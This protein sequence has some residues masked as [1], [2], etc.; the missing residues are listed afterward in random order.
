M[1]RSAD[2]IRRTFRRMA[3]ISKR[4]SEGIDGDIAAL[5][6]ELRRLQAE[7]LAIINKDLIGGLSIGEGGTVSKGA[8]NLSKVAKV[9]TIFAK[10]RRLFLRSLVSI[11]GQN[12]LKIAGKVAEYFR[13]GD[14]R[15]DSVER[16]ARTSAAIEARIG[17]ADGR[18]IVGGYLDTLANTDV[19]K[20]EL[21]TFMLR[22]I[23]NG[24]SLADLTAGLASLVVGNAD[25]DGFLVR[26]FRQYAYDTFN[27]VREIK[28]QEFAE[29]LNL[30]WFI[31]Q[32]SLIE[33]SRRFCEKRAGKV[34][35]TEETKT[36]KNDQ[37]LV[38]PKTKNTYNPLIE[39]GRYNCRHW[40]DYISQ[41]TAEY[42][43]ANP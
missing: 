31:Y 40:I 20:Q 41:E 43:K 3:A 26:Y 28:N 23:T 18:L 11:F 25:A 16:V 30:K 37:D 32:G 27:Q 6:S 39:R 34:F 21:K 38:E 33:T 35:N 4:I 14:F 5:D 19:L 24:V 36:W 17:I 2:E 7:L 1:P 42:L 9:D 13:A 15:Q 29:G 10:F 8:R 22:S 12:L